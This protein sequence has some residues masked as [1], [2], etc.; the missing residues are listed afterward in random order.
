MDFDITVEEIFSEEG[1]LKD[2]LP[3]YEYRDS[4]KN[5]AVFIEQCAAENS[6]ALIEAGTGTGKTMAYLVPVIKYAMDS[7]KKI[8]VSTETKALQ[9][10]LLEKDIP[11]AE[12]IMK[13]L[14]G[15][16][17]KTSL[18]LGSSNYPCYTR[19]KGVVGHGAFLFG[20]RDA[21][22]EIATMFES[23][24]VFTFEDTSVEWDFWSQINREPESCNMKTCKN[25]TQCVYCRV[26]NEWSRA[27]LLIMNHYLFFANLKSGRTFLPQFDV[28]V[29]DEAHSL[30][31][32]ASSQMGFEINKKITGDIVSRIRKSRNEL[33]FDKIDSKDIQKELAADFK[34]F[35]EELP[36]FFSALQEK[37]GENLNIRLK[38]GFPEGE[39]LLKSVES[40]YK[41]FQK[42]EKDF[43]TNEFTKMEYDAL[44]SRLFS[45]YQSLNM[46]VYGF[47]KNWV[48]WIESSRD[49]VT[50]VAQ[51]VDIRD[52]MRHDVFEFFESSFFIS[53][54]LTVNNS[55]DYTIRKLGLHEPRKLMLGSPFNY[56]ENCILYIPDTE[57]NPQSDLYTRY[58]AEITAFLIE[59]SGGRTMVL[60]T[61]Y[62]MLEDC[63]QILS[64]LVE[65]E[66]YSQNESS[67]A[68]AISSYRENV[69][70]VLL[71]THSFWQG[72]DLQGDS[73]KNLVITRLP[74]AVPD[75]PLIEAR[76]E[77]IT[78]SGGN[79]F[80][81][82]QIP[83][84]V[85]K[86]RQ[87]FGRLIR[88]S[89]DTG[90]VAVLDNRIIQKNYG[91]YFLNSLPV[92]RI[93]KDLKQL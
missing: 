4:Q 70:S 43:S 39:A 48:Y 91:K 90:I 53:A 34:K 61:S 11:S 87:G 1:C 64:G 13:E 42:T 24:L 7:G 85:I 56:R 50:L 74:F 77:K 9:R 65:C 30:E 83:E 58:V 32:V 2:I 8:A 20:D 81:D 51:P 41:N 72:I 5:M 19:Y 60:F 84:A 36:G 59:K 35:T 16:N 33:V 92:C 82:F 71:G 89:T 15:Y 55:F 73:L 21:A 14:Y 62:K 17:V 93:V 80:F 47:E 52:I 25:K 27:D 68:R 63:R 57:I 88:S 6:D 67:A 40:F 12:K 49:D 46:T 37:L 54:T 26:R 66:I 44:S 28:I 86:F 22:D 23:G 18:C 38:K 29:F 45:L 10:Q 79:S 76:I 31:T 69:N 3:F 75:K 78:E